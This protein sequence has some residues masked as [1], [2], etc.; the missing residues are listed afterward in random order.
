MRRSHQDWTYPVI[1]ATL[2]SNWKEKPRLAVQ[3]VATLLHGILDALNLN[4]TSRCPLED[5]HLD[6]VAIA[7]NTAY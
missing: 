1:T 3:G 6:N 7:N 2:S 4:M 5:H